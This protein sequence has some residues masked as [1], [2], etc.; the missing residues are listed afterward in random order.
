MRDSSGKFIEIEYNLDWVENHSEPIT[1]CGC[2]LWS[3]YQNKDNGYGYYRSVTKG[4]SW[5]A[6][7]FVFNIVNGYYPK[8]VMHSCDN[9]LCVNP[10]HLSA[11]T[12]KKNLQDMVDRG[13]GGSTM[14]KRRITDTTRQKI[15]EAIGTQAYIAKLFNVSPSTVSRIIA[16]KDT[17]RTRYS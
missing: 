14:F 5:L 9:R 11:G 6:H 13:R 7:R 12:Q 3:G 15:K 10:A 17:N 16:G 8:L 2:W 4:K 1:E